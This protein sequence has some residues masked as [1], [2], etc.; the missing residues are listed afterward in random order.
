MHGGGKG[1]KSPSLLFGVNS[2]SLHPRTQEQKHERQ[3]AGALPFQVV[4]DDFCTFENS[5][6]NPD[7][8]LDNK[9][10]EEPDEKDW[11]PGLTRRLLFV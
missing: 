1:S 11:P 4:V 10:G 3:D 5:E 8:C 6:R 2:Q 7:S 9:C